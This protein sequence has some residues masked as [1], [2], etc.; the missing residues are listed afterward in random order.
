MSMVTQPEYDT[1]LLTGIRVGL[2]KA[3]ELGYTVE[4]MDVSASVSEGLCAIHFAPVSAPGFI[5]AGGDLSLTVN[6][7]SEEVVEYKRGQ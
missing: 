4:N 3:R 7:C 1:Q 2:L 5:T 6:V